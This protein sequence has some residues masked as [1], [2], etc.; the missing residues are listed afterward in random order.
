VDPVTHMVTGALVAQSMAPPEQRWA[1]ALVAAGAAAAPDIDF[2]ARKAESKLLFLQLHRGATHSLLATPVIAAAA[3][4]CGHLLFGLPLWPLLQTCWAALLTHLVLDTVMH[5]TGLR[6]L[7]PLQRRWSLPLIVGLNPLTSSARCGERSFGVCLR[8]TMHSAAL[9]PLVLLTWAGFLVSLLLPGWA[10]TASQLTL[11][12]MAAYL[13][14][15]AVMGL[16]ARRQLRQRAP[17]SPVLRV[18]PAGFS[19]TRWLGVTVTP[20]GEE[21]TVWLVDALRDAASPVGQYPPSATTDEALATASTETVR[22][23]LDNAIFPYASIHGHRQGTVVVW[24]D[25][26]FAFSPTVSLFAA[27]VQLDPAGQVTAEEFRE[28]W[29]HAPERLD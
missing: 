15:A 1:F 11:A 22:E 9:S 23:F 6:W 7:W 14:L 26:A 13:G 19:P 4:G 2:I 12:A 27:R 16:R 28:R 21:H 24:R 17:D 29:D 18:F 25:L 10:R 3:A 20:A 5:S 8:C